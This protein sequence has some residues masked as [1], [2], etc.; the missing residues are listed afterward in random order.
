MGQKTNPNIF[1]LGINKTWKTEFFEK[2]Q[3]E[4]PLYTFKDLEIKKYVERFLEVQG[5]LLHDYKQHYSD[6]TLHLY[7]SYF[8]S[9][10]FNLQRKESKKSLMLVNSS[11]EKKLVFGDKKG[12]QSVNFE[13]SDAKSL[14]AQHKSNSKS[15]YKIKKYL[16][17]HSS[18]SEKILKLST[19]NKVK[20]DSKDHLLR[21][22]VEGILNNMF[23][24]LAL[25]TR[26]KFN[27]V[28]SFCCLNKNLTFLKNTQRKNF[29]MLQKFKSTPFLKEG[30]ELLF[31]VVYNRN[32]A[33]L[34]AKF[35]AIQIKKVKRH[36]FFLSFLK[37]TLTTLLSSSLVK[38]K[39]IKILISG[40][41]N[42]VPRAN[43]K[44]I[45]IGDVPVQSLN[46]KV[47]YA[48]LTAHNSNGS[49]GIKVWVIEKD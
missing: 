40:R 2:K 26:N 37:Q 47:D 34:L 31:H 11:E 33:A 35:V 3:H 23:K 4:F 7:I 42:G 14:K 17:Q 46:A 32:S 8:I 16:N 22:K 13:I 45:S 29:I 36:K 21:L 24:V 27:I 12:N 18:T 25:F 5:I 30:M 39:G 38:V 19:L 20:N 15:F 9:S 41:L 1:R 10:E 43:H 48:Q 28:V 44:I 49:Y 6:S